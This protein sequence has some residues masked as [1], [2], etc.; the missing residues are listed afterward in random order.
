M[1]LDTLRIL[2]NPFELVKFRYTK[3]VGKLFCLTL[4]QGFLL[5]FVTDQSHTREYEAFDFC[6]HES[7]SNP[8]AYV[9]KTCI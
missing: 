9:E 4:V 6:Y 5:N 8:D 2:E 1:S 7:V 3:I